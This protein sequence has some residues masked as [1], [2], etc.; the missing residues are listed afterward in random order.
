MN[1]VPIRLI[2][3][4]FMF[5]AIVAL[6]VFLSKR[7][8]KWLGLILPTL[9]FIYSLLMLPMIIAFETLGKGQLSI[10]I[11]ANLL[12]FNLPTIILLAIY[13][14]LKEKRTLHSQID[15]MNIKDL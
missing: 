4:L 6:Q 7:R 10:M 2:F 9:S 14:G 3:L 15:K 1:N 12:I 13:W 8:N 11:F 5:A